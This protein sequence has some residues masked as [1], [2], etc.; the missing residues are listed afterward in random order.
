MFIEKKTLLIIPVK[1]QTTVLCL[2]HCEESDWADDVAIS[3]HALSLSGRN[4]GHNS[5]LVV[6]NLV[7]DG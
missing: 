6:K 2:C 3:Y 4:A 7:A 5:K 1:E